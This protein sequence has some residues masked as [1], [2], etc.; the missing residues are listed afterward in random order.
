LPPA[1][2]RMRR[3]ASLHS[4]PRCEE[5]ETRQLLTIYHVGVTDPDATWHS[6]A[7]VNRFAAETGFVAGDQILL[8]SRQTFA[9]NLYLQSADEVTNMGPPDAPITIG[10]YDS[11]NPAN[12]LPAAATIDAGA[13]DGIKV[14]N[15]A[16][17]HISDLKIQGGWN[18]E[19][20]TG[21][22]GDGIFFDG[23]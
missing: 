17:F 8:E 3:P 20:A 4:R 2:R 21:N 16:G 9:G 7:D 19:T 5:L 23:N 22:A 6:I 18:H 13:G 11:V 10:S 12:P 15:A 14:F 1:D